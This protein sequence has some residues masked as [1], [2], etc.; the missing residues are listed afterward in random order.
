MLKSGALLC[1]IMFSFSTLF[2]Q[3][4]LYKEVKNTEISILSA[5]A[6]TMLGVLY[7][8]VMRPAHQ[9]SIKVD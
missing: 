8:L 1:I 2:S 3:E 9:R 6:F 4:E 7:E 5:P